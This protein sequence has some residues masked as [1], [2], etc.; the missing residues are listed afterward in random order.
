VPGTLGCPFVMTADDITRRWTLNA[1]DEHAVAAGYRFDE[2]RGMFVVDWLHDHLCLY[3]G[4]WA[5]QPFDCVDWQYDATM[6]MF[7]WVKFSERW[8]REIRRFRQASVWVPK[9]NKKSPTLAAWGIYLTCGDGEQGQKFYF[10]A[11]DGNQAR[12]M[13][14]KHAIEMVRASPM[15]MAE[16]TINKTMMQITHERSRSLMKPLSS[17]NV[18]SQEAKEGLNGSIGVDETHVVDDAFMGR[19]DRAGIS[20]SEPLLIEVSTAGDNPEGYGRARYEYAKRVLSGEH[21]DHQTLA[22][23]HEAPQDL[24][25]A[26]LDADPVKYGKLANPA[27]GHTIGEEE[28]VSDYARSKVSITKLARFK[29]YRLNIWQRAS[30]PWLRQDDWVKCRREFA[31]A[32]LYGVP[33]GA[34]LDLSKTEDMTSL[35]LAFPEGEAVGEEDLPCKI[36]SWFWLPQAAVDRHSHETDY[37]QWQADGWLRVIPGEV[38]DYSFVERDI[39][40]ILDKFDVRLL[41]FDR[42]YA[43]ELTQR[44]VQEH[45]FPQTSLFEFPQ[46]IMAFAGPTAQFERLVIAGKL[47]HNSHPILTWQAGHVQV[48]HDANAN[49]RPVKPPHGDIRKID[50][51]VAGIMASDAATRMPAP[52]PYATRGIVLI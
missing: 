24:S 39:A 36:L 22:I 29:M 47:H 11:K 52:S 8:G 23:V 40:E 34:G 30:N 5:G 51:I 6:R 3:E 42:H 7:G 14:G 2:E 20:R 15:L 12:E 27:W 4:E 50:G 21:I 10:A 16:C 48:K 35:V 46:T 41:G 13:V 19:I 37:A 38:I 44:L 18:R 45:G 33:C 43:F 28:Y 31:E 17:D 49:I 26:D 9:K 25:D 1:S 32:D